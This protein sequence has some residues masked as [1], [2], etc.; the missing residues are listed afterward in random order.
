MAGRCGNRFSGLPRTGR[1]LRADS[2][3]NPIATAEVVDP[4]RMPWPERR[5]PDIYLSP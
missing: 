3:E 4:V 5:P 2:P 1:V